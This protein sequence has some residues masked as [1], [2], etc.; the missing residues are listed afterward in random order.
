MDRSGFITLYHACEQGA[1]RFGKRSPPEADEH[2][3]EACNPPA[4]DHRATDGVMKPLLKTINGN[5][6]HIVLSFL[7]DS[8]SEAA[9][10][11]QSLPRVR[12]TGSLW[13]EPSGASWQVPRCCCRAFRSPRNIVQHAV[14]AEAISVQRYQ[15]GYPPCT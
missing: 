6:T 14:A 9:P 11:Q 5:L 13:L 3:R 10:Q 8:P 4:A 7:V 15:I 2:L 12:L 1:G